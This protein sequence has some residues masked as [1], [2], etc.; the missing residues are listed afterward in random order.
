MYASF[1][2][3][4][5]LPWL[6]DK[7]WSTVPGSL[8]DAASSPFFTG[9]FLSSVLF[10][11]YISRFECKFHRALQTSAKTYIFFQLV[12]LCLLCRLENM[13][14]H[15]ACRYV[16]FLHAGT[17]GSCELHC[18]CST[19]PPH[20][21]SSCTPNQLANC[22]SHSTISTMLYILGYSVVR[23]NYLSERSR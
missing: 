2:E 23:G 11:V 4:G 17:L 10:A 20:Y 16:C 12:V 15:G 5:W 6:R 14:M 19:T 1:L 22:K 9:L 21:F 8:A 7:W 3:E 13:Y 18:T